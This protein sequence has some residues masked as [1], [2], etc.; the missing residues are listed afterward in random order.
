M[1]V[2]SVPIKGVLVTG[3]TTPIGERLIRSL[4]ADPEI[5]AILAV[6]QEPEDQALPFSHGER[7]VY[8]SVDLG[9]SRR[10]RNLLF[11]PA[12]EMGIEVVIHT[13]MHRDAKDSGGRV[14]RSNVDALRSLLDLSDRHPTIRRFVFKSYAEVYQVQHDLPILV[15]ED[16]PLNMS[17]GSPQWVRDRV[18]ADLTACTRMGLTNLEIAVL[19]CAEILAPG[20]GSQLFDYLDA[21]VCLRPVGFDPMMNLLSISD[22]V[23]SMELAARAFG[24]QGVFNVPGLDTLP[25]SA[26]IRR[27]G[28]LGLPLPQPAITPWYRLRRRIRGHDFSYG[29]N[30]RRFHYCSV[31][32]GTRARET[33]GFEPENAIDWPAP[34]DPAG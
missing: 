31:L 24:V 25:L 18:E 22:A 33:L 12:R 14:R 19:R 28:C 10:V 15:T 21:K 11:G 30:R 29:M 17:P 27:W 20:T 2:P 3:A 23:R 5:E 26:C 13:A 16:H 1:P 9:R 4:L 6:G 8:R 7:L 32:D 34:V